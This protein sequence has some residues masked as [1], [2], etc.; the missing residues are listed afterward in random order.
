[1]Q[2]LLQEHHSVSRKIVHILFSTTATTP[3]ADTYEWNLGTGWTNISTS[4]G[5]LTVTATATG[6]AIS[7]SIRVTP[8]GIGGCDGGI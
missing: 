5:G 2:M 4:N 3:A 7:D 6:A 8:K 1:M